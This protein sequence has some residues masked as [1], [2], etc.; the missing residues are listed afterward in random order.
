MTWK[1]NKEA[2]NRTPKFISTAIVQS[3]LKVSAIHFFQVHGEVY[4]IRLLVSRVDKMPLILHLFCRRLNFVLSGLIINISRVNLTYIIHYTFSPF[5]L[6]F[7]FVYQHLF[8]YIIFLEQIF[9]IHIG[10][11]QVLWNLRGLEEL[12][13]EGLTSNKLIKEVHQWKEYMLA[14]NTNKRKEKLTL[15]AFLLFHRVHCWKKQLFRR[16]S[17]KWFLKVITVSK[18]HKNI[19]HLSSMIEK[20]ESCIWK[21]KVSSQHT[22][23]FASLW[24]V[25]LLIGPYVTIHASKP[26]V[27]R[28]VELSFTYMCA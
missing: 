28:F 23:V 15:T 22:T 19:F 2:C 9:Q 25:H 7:V 21:R 4:E 24:N 27:A 16:V 3:G 8:H 17:L 5:L 6:S 26:Q 11:L 14:F 1:P 10:L 12:E 18:Y 13:L 20:G